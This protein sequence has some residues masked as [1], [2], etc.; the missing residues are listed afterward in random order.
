MKQLVILTALGLSLSVA[1]SS[2]AS[3]SIASFFTS[4]KRNAR[5]KTEESELC[6]WLPR[7]RSGTFE[8]EV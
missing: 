7:R 2:W 3:H 8:S 5:R 4:E 1:T 6:K